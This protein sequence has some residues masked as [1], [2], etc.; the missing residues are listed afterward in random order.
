M[1]NVGL[2]PVAANITSTQSEA[3][4]LMRRLRRFSAETG[5]PA[6]MSATR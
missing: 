5:A 1:V 2:P 6:T 4:V 3:R